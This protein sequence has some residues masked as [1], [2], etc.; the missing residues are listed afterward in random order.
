M[1]ARPRVLELVNAAWTTQVLAAACEVGIPDA[2]DAPATAEAIAERTASNPDAVKRVLH[3]LVTL[4]LCEER[5]VGAFTLTPDGE[6]LRRDHPESLSAWARMSGA[7]IWNNWGL[8]AASVRSGESARRKLLGTDDFSYLDADAGRAEVFNA[9][10]VDLTRPVA[11]AAARLVDWSTIGSAVDVGGGV[12][13]LLAGIAAAHPHLRG[14]VF[15]LRHA[16]EGAHAHLRRRGVADRCGVEAG[17]FFDAVPSGHDGYMLKS[18]LHNWGDADALRILERVRQAMAPG[19]RVFVFER[20]LPE[21][22]STGAADRDLAR[23]D[24]NMLVG[25]G[26][27]ERTA[28]EFQSLLASAGMTPG[29]IRPMSAGGMHVITSTAQ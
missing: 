1:G 14:V 5:G 25:C 3:A 29:D 6:L 8:L 13:E 18:V 12:G 4:G 17:S 10:M 26:G 2:M 20:V 24:L 27:R 9:A 16:V 19:A 11:E 15:D 28:A 21:H 23:S 22:F 7:Q